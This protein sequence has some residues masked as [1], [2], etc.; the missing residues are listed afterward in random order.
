M[1]L[2]NQNFFIDNNNETNK[3]SYN[4]NELFQK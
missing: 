2:K 3:F 1:E 4:N